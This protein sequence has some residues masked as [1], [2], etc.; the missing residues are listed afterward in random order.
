MDLTYRLKLNVSLCK[1]QNYLLR[2]Y[3][4]M[5]EQMLRRPASFRI[6]LKAMPQKRSSCFVERIWHRRRFLILCNFVHN[7]IRV[8]NIRPWGGTSGHFNHSAAKTP[9]I[10]LPSNVVTYVLNGLGGHP[11]NAAQHNA[12]TVAF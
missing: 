5:F 7:C 3:K 8:V 6:T 4:F 10:A 11:W 12:V 9:N 1:R 2:L